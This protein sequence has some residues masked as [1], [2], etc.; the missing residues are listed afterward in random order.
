MEKTIPENQ[1]TGKLYR[2]RWVNT[3]GPGK[4]VSRNTYSKRDANKLA[5][6]LN[7]DH[8]KIKHTVEPA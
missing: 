3:D 5:D 1:D 8:P 7:E 4:G 2:I 6:E